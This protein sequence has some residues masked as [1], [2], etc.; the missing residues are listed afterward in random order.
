MINDRIK[1]EYPDHVILPLH[2]VIHQESLCKSVLKIKHVIDPV[3][4]VVNLIR[5]RGLS[6]RQFKAL[7]D[8]LETEHSDVLHSSMVESRKGFKESMGS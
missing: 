5:S 6:Q 7:L 3:V 8:D 2:C 4:G 1:S